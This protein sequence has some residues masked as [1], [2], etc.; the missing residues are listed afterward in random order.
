VLREV[1]I[2]WHYNEDS[3]VSAVR[4][5]LAMIRELLVI[6]WNDRLGRYDK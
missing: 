6:R 3:R 1:P 2:D 5:S 4:D